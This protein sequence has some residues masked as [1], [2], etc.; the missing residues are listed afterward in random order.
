MYAD[1]T[2]VQDE[3]DCLSTDCEDCVWP[4]NNLPRQ[5]PCLLCDPG[6]FLRTDRGAC[7]G[8]CKEGRGFIKSIDNNGYKNCSKPPA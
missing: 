7:F 6:K 8:K 1:G 5:S 3:C 2:V 4:V